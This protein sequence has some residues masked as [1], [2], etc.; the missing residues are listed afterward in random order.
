MFVHNMVGIVLKFTEP[1][2]AR[3]PPSKG[4]KW[5]FYVFKVIKTINVLYVYIE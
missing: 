4:K 2:D 1:A 3:V 5:R